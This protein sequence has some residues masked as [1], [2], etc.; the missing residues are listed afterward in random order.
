VVVYTDRP[1]AL[2]R[3][4]LAVGS[5]AGEAVTARL[6]RKEIAAATRLD[7]V[8]EIRY[9]GAAR[10]HNDVAAGL[11]GIRSLN[12]GRLNGTAYTG[13]GVIACVIDSGVDWKHLDFRS[14]T[15]TT[16]SRIRAL[17]DQTLTAEGDE[18]TPG[19]RR[20][21]ASGAYDYGVEYTRAAIEDEI[22][23][24]PAGEV[25]SRDT[26]GHG[27]HVAATLAA[28]GGAHE[29][30]AH[31]G[32]AP[33]ADLIVVKAG[34]ESFPFTNVIDGMNYCGE[35]AADAGRPLVVNMSLGADFGPHDGTL[36]QDRAIETFARD[37]AGRVVV[38]SAGNSGNSGIHVRRTL[39]ANGASES[40]TVNVPEAVSGG[41]FRMD[42]W[43]DDASDVSVEVTSPN[44]E[45][46][47]QA[48]GGT[49][50][51]DTPDGQ[52][53]LENV[54]SSSV[55]GGDR[56]IHVDVDDDGGDAPAQ[57]DWT[58]TLA[59][60]SSAPVGVHGWLYD[61]EVTD[62]VRASLSGGD[63]AY[64]V[65]TPGSSSGS[66]TV[67]ASVHRQ[68]WVAEN[69]SGYSS[70]SVS[71]SDDIAAFSSRG[72]LRESPT[73]AQKPT[74]TAPGQLTGSALSADAP[75]TDA[76]VLPGGEHVLK[77]GTS[78]AA[79]VVSGAAALLLQEQGDLD[80]ARLKALL[81]GS[82]RRG[83]FSGAVPNADWGHGRLDAVGAM[84][85]LLDAGGSASREVLAYDQWSGGGARTVQGAERLAVRFTPSFDGVVSGG[86]L[87]AWLPTRLS[88]GA[89]IE[90]W[91]DDGAGA[92]GQRRGAAQAL[93][94][95]RL[96]DGSWTY[97]DLVDAGVSVEAGTDYHL[98]VSL[99]AA[100]DE[101]AFRV[102]TGSPD[103][104]TSLQGGGAWTAAPY[105]ARLRAVVTTSSAGGQLPVELADFEARASGD[106]VV[107]SWRTVSE[108]SNARFEVQ[109]APEAGPAA[110]RWATVG[111]VP[112]SGTTTEGRSYRFTDAGAPYGADSLAYR[113]R[114]VDVDGAATLSAPVT[115]AR[116]VDRVELLGTAPNP[117][118]GRAT[119][120]F[121]VP[122]RQKVIL[123]LYDLLGRQV[124]T[125]VDG[126]REGREEAV[127]DA[128]DLPSGVYL[129]RLQ[130]PGGSRTQKLT[131]VR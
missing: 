129:L 97:L 25:R 82:A 93:D 35:V 102:D 56:Q 7:G 118:R 71:R 57:G 68:Y 96:Q 16:A 119:I 13:E 19:G 24:S 74:L 29:A 42:F 12:N 6:T 98:V 40:V 126:P 92:P 107:L 58:I 51:T 122:T 17:W 20:S 31:R 112:G 90:V 38:T 73:G 62:D 41:E 2:R 99:P 124:K 44:G 11:T 39:A 49:S 22:D 87:H 91:T 77:R 86:L 30:G 85:R 95:A 28:T 105:D 59:N 43:V 21:F 52:I 10:P 116:S 109:R 55:G 94:G 47:R 78:M 120:R 45:T 130:H 72:P 14:T 36:F 121:A 65:G 81:A 115:V 106:E 69:G 70:G 125:L 61:A 27:T 37:R 15:D 34:D 128:S 80:A 9:G 117:V 108:R 123:R 111:S 4:G 83:S 110:R 79:P 50:T 63:N 60:A 8:H 48:P 53:G 89:T 32:M 23:G 26:D 33:G 5:R 46:A 54:T 76:L 127:L 101:L 75:A 1:E 18:A 64:T 67:A 103:G 114:Q 100:G 131:V 84:T 66:V 113:L 104:R 88:A 3:A